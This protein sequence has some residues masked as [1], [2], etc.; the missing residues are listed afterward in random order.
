MANVYKVLGQVAPPATS[1][2]TL[3]TAANPS[4]ASTITV[5]NRGASSGSYRIAVR[6]GAAAID[7]RHYVAYDTAIPGNSTDCITIGLTVAAGDVVSVYA[8]SGDFSF[9]LFGSEVD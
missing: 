8:S 1:L 7:N 5:C 2:T 9:S 4:V 3:Y 6:P